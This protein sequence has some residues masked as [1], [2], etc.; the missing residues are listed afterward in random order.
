MRRDI[1]ISAFW[2]YKKEKE[3]VKKNSDILTKKKKKS[4]P[5]THLIT[6][7]L[8]QPGRVRATT[9]ICKFE[10]FFTVHCWM[11]L[12][13]VLS[14]QIETFEIPQFIP[15]ALTF[16]SWKKQ[17][18]VLMPSHPFSSTI[19]SDNQSGELCSIPADLGNSM[20]FICTVFFPFVECYMFV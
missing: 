8:K 20:S 5:L 13:Y 3:E 14:Y 12:V 18:H 7:Q 16:Y 6:R 9:W 15:V 4:L 1:F 19:S 2:N 11:R 17:V 10:S